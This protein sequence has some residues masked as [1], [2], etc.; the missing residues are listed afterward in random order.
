MHDLGPPIAE[1]HRDAS[2]DV[3]MHPDAS[4]HK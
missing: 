4:G 2:G 1:M 3:S